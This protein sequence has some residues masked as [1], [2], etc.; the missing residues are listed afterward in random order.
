VLLERDAELEVLEALLGTLDLS[1]GKVVLLRGEAGIGK[2]S[3]VAEFLRRHADDAH[4]AVGY[5]DNLVT[6][7]PLGPFSDF[8]RHEP[9]LREPLDR[10]DRQAVLAGCLD[11][12]SRAARPSILVFEDT[13]WAD[14]A[15]LDAVKY[16]GRRIART[17]GLLLLTY[18]DGEVDFDHPLRAVIGELSPQNVVRVQL[19]RL[20]DA[21]V[22]TML[23]DAEAVLELED[24]IALTN[25][26]PHFV[27]EVIAGGVH[28]VPISV[29]DS[30]LARA[31][32]LSPTSRRLLDLASVNPGRSERRHLID[33]VEAA[34]EHFAECARQGLI[35]VS[36]E[37]VAFR[38]ELSRRA[39]EAALGLEQ[40]RN[41]NRAMLGALTPTGDLSR[42]VHHAVQADDIDAII[43][44]APRAAR[45]A[46]ACLSHREANA[47][48]WTL[49]P[50]LD[51]L[52]GGERADIVEDW[53]RVAFYLH[54]NGAVDLLTR[55]IALR[56][57]LPDHRALSRLLMFAIRVYEVTGRPADAA[58]CSGE[59][60]AML[61]GPPSG[62]LAFALSQR[63]WL[64]LM[65]SD[66]DDA[67]L[68]F[69]DRAL[70]MGYAT[71]HELAVIYALVTKGSL[72]SGRGDAAGLALVEESHRRSQRGGFHYEE[73]DALI[74]LA[75][76]A[77]DV[78]QIQLAADFARRAVSTAA[79]YELRSLE[80]A[81]HAVHAE[82]Q[83]WLGDWGSAEDTATNVLGSP[84]NLEAL[85]WRVLG[86]LWLREGRPGARNALETMW[87]AAT[88]SGELQAI[89][90]AAAALAEFMW[91]SGE[92]NPE[93]MS[94]LDSAFA[95]GVAV[96]TPWPSGALVFW[97]WKIGRIT[98][99]PDGLVDLFR[100]II[101]GQPRAA[102]QRW[103]A[104]GA[105]YEQ[106]IALSHGDYDAQ[107]QALE[108]LESLGARAV[109]TAIRKAMRSSGLAIPRGRGKATR[110]S[111]GGLTARQSEVLALL[112]AGLPNAAIADSLF[113]SPRTVEH[114]VSAVLAKL[115]ATT[116]EQAV[117]KA[118]ADGLLDSQK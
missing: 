100:L 65:R 21:A 4:I 20:S 71:G 85:A 91:L 80:A 48:F 55:A 106:A 56:R 68:Q 74:N 57:S 32:R 102:A 13:H 53:A 7:Q 16:L 115:N 73:V 99:V 45:A 107:L 83:L 19:T 72:E 111:I 75:G 94:R 70:E 52:S 5:C 59:A 84:T 41:L 79:R 12:L 86:T 88:T 64:G 18:R 8:A 3:L 38:H 30:V 49:A 63:A 97:M 89:D 118:R 9:T 113:L 93:L 109:A 50:Y 67:T 108:I 76:L 15:T 25:G 105:P 28:G 87:A 10:G 90:P 98:D 17:N 43:E 31:A 26:N 47:H 110:A 22:A 51:R 6:P 14:E 114:H 39:I 66:D 78:R 58:S 116:R 69:A 103:F 117:A 60:I 46:I 77:G 112:G 40:R 36:G 92:R 101:D 96:G 2:S 35:D 82:I 23:A 24:V 81:A 104:A 11:L 42:L 95:A 1:G 44:L 61:E 29:Q 27:T 54:D 62:D 37:T 33:L 34:A